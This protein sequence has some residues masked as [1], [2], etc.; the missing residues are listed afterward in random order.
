MPVLYEGIKERPYPSGDSVGPFSGIN[1]DKTVVT[2]KS[3]VV[4]VP[5]NYTIPVLYKASDDR[6]LPMRISHG[7]RIENINTSNGYGYAT[8][9]MA[10][11]LG[12]LGHEFVQNDPDAP[13]QIW[14]DQPHHW[15]WNDSTQYRIGY[16][17]W[18]STLLKDGWA[19][20]FNECDEIWTPS[21][22][23]AEWYKKYNNVKPPVYVYQHGVDPIWTPQKRTNRNR[24]L[25]F[26]HLGF[27]AVR[28]G[29]LDAKNAFREAFGNRDDV[30][31]TLKMFSPGLGAGLLE[32]NNVKVINRKMELDE[33]VEL[34]N[35]HDVF[36]Y[37]TWGEGFGL[38]PIQALA[39]GMPTISTAGVLPYEKYMDPRL[40]IKSRLRVPVVPNPSLAWTRHHP[41]M[42]QGPLVTDIPHRLKWIDENYKEAR[43]FALSKVEELTKE[44]DWVSLTRTA[45]DDLETRLKNR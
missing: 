34:F 29:G 43:D 30:E 25:R 6:I 17:P 1:I 33:L 14:F 28:K 32:T 22:L 11:A 18:E 24:P 45:F 42:L 12:A 8:D 4:Y 40:V 3:P 19:E 36:L 39:T 7:T 2:D 35:S 9:R 44:Y 16:H 41:G 23:I 37:P 20:K 31:L 38:T 5:T 15:K 10:A 21:P 13:V 26:L 27:E